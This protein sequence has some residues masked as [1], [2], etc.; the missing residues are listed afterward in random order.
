[1]LIR[2]IVTP[3]RKKVRAV[4]ETT[5]M[6]IRPHLNSIACGFFLVGGDKQEGPEKTIER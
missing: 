5:Q 1:M 3:P 2:A 6:T 4:V